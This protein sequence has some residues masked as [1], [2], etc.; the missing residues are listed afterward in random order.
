M[1]EKTN[2][3][4]KR[5]F[6]KFKNY[7]AWEQRKLGEV[8][9]ITMGQ[10][11]NGKNYTENPVDHILV[12]G[13]ADMKNGRV[14]PRIWTTQITKTA[15]PNDII[16]S[17]RA[18]VGDVGK[19]DYDVV[20]GRGVAG[21]KGNNFVYQLLIKMKETGFWTRYS[22]GSTFESINSTDLKDAVISIPNE[23]EQQKIGTF[24]KQL[25]DTI[26]LHQRKLEKLQALRSAYL[27]EMFSSE[28]EKRPKRRFA[29]FDDDWEQYKLIKFADLFDNLRVPVT[30]SQREKGD[31]PYYGANGIQDYVSGFTHEGEFVLIAEDG[32]NDLINYPVQYVNGKIWV[33]NHAHVVSGKTGKLDNLFLTSRIKAM[34]IST[35]LVGG[36]R[37]KLNGEVLKNIPILVPS[38]QEQQMIGEFFERLESNIMLHQSKLDKLKNIKKA[39]LNEMFV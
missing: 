28:D 17:V 5:R 1:T 13:N 39:Y 9:Q 6:E 33:N 16:L 30:A 4:P 15:E 23:K 8:V 29:G 27:S 25:D 36:G 19:T 38:L 34:N 21:I 32:A 26:A 18:P 24:F 37:A 20:L 31:V 3:I 7:D 12:Q 2:L 22:T 14:V 11:P 35:W 10:S